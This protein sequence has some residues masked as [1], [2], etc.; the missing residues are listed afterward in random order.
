VWRLQ[1]PHRCAG[2]LRGRRPLISK[3]K[4]AERLRCRRHRLGAPTNRMNCGRH[5]VRVSLNRA[6]D[7]FLSTALVGDQLIRRN[8]F[9]ALMSVALVLLCC[10][11]ASRLL[12]GALIPNA[13]SANGTTKIPILVATTRNRT[14]SDPSEMFDSNRAPEVAYASIVVSIPPDS[15]RQIGEIQWPSAPPGDPARFE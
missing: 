9:S 8:V 11:C 12:Q 4:R 6:N 1:S 10:S 14:T 13:Q 15:A 3:C 7:L 5:L 2:K